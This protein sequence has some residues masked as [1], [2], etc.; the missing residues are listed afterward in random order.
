MKFILLCID[1]WW[2]LMG[3]YRGE[4]CDAANYKFAEKSG[5][6]KRCFFV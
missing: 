3:D 6:L 5:K 1:G 4:D 2:S